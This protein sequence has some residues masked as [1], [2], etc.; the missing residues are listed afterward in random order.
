ML[1]FKNRIDAG[2]QLVEKLRKYDGKADVVVLGIP[3]GGVVIASIVSKALHLPLDVIVIKKI[4]LPGNEEF[5]IGAT[6]PEISHIDQNKI[7]GFGISKESLNDRIEMK[8]KEAKE[9]YDFLSAGRAP[10]SLKGK[11]V[12]LIDDGTATGETMNL[13][14]QI[15]KGQGAK[16]V[17][18]AV[19]VASEDSLKGLG[20]DEVVCILKPG[21][22]GAIGEFYDDFLQV[23]DSE[24]KG[25][26]ANG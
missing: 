14:V 5:A 24:V 10:E 2:E 13:A 8:K 7:K 26:L 25:L 19:P 16:G 21:N 22:L 6:S 1:M 12:V 3:R 9:R 11:E 23:E 18:V 4:G 17:V 15:V 20:A